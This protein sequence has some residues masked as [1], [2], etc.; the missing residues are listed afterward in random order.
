M[1]PLCIS[2]LLEQLLLSKVDQ[3]VEKYLGKIQKCFQ[4]ETDFTEVLEREIAE[5]KAQIDQVGL[6]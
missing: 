6:F 3:T 1:I 5:T 2:D 4:E